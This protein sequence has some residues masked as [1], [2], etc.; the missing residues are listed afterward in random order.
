SGATNRALSAGG[1]STI[2]CFDCD[3]TGAGDPS[4]IQAFSA[5]EIR[6]SNCVIDQ[7]ALCLAQ[8]GVIRIYAC[9]DPDENAYVV[10]GNIPINAMGRGSLITGLAPPMRTVTTG[11]GNTTWLVSDPDTLIYT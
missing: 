3:L 4:P 10:K 6:A 1:G 5:C 2:V 8:G 9:V 11:S 7:A